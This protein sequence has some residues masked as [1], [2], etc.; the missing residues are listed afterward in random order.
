MGRS[1]PAGRRWTVRLAA[2]CLVAQALPA[3]A[4]PAAEP[5]LAVDRTTVRAGDR[6]QVRVAGWR[7]GNL[8]LEVCG[9]EA[10]NG[11]IDCAVDAA[12]N[13]PVGADGI[14]GALVRVTVPPAPCPCVLRA[15]A[16]VGGT[17]R[18]IALAIQGAPTRPA[19]SR[20]TVTRPVTSVGITATRLGGGGSGW[21]ALLGG[22]A[23]RTLWVTVRNTG[24]APVP[25][26]RLSVVAG[27]P[28]EPTTIVVAP[29]VGL[30]APG[31]QRTVQVP[32]TFGTPTW[33]RY[34]VRAE[35]SGGEQPA[36]GYA[37]TSSY[38]WGLFVLLALAGG[39]GL[40]RL[41][42]RRGAVPGGGAG[43]CAATLAGPRTLI[44]S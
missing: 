1:R 31:E 24:A 14:G 21:A 2:A 33:G 10:V 40:H 42:R 15:R 13:V 29:P 16:L 7:P 38:P 23:R 28:G 12:A 5:A 11:S 41:V 26:A 8:A 37:H 22:P 6:V 44:G 36:V 20:A 4:A 43:R 19:G 35:A 32:I 25:D 17:V 27:R 9:N 18:A 30:L 39:L 34:T 3:S